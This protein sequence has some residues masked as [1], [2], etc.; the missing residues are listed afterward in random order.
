[1]LE[2]GEVKKALCNKKVSLIKRH[3]KGREKQGELSQE[4]H[5]TI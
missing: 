3:N 1:M 2:A 5:E 4:K